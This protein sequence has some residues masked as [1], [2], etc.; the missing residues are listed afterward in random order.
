VWSFVV[1]FLSCVCVYD[2]FLFHVNGSHEQYEHPPHPLPFLSSGS[3]N[4]SS[5]GRGLIAFQPGRIA[6]EPA[7]T[8]IT[9]TSTPISAYRAARGN[10]NP[11]SCLNCNSPLLTNPSLSF[12]FSGAAGGRSV[13]RR[14]IVPQPCRRA[15]YC[16]P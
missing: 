16:F 3:A 2:L 4:G 12:L 5:I 9:L 10:P 7:L 13:G 11:L 6:A 1:W 14:T 8:I 15:S